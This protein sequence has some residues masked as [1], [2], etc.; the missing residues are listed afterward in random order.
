MRWHKVKDKMPPEH[1]S[2]LV[3][4]DYR[5]KHSCMVLCYNYSGNVGL[6]IWYADRAQYNVDP[7]DS[8][9]EIEMPED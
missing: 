6:P 1:E 9:C 8:W 4:F 7:K 3:C 5:N 2:V